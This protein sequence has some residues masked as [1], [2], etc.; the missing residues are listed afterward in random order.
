MLSRGKAY[1]FDDIC[2][3][4]DTDT[5]KS[6]REVIFKFLSDDRY[7]YQ[8]PN[9]VNSPRQKSIHALEGVYSKLNIMDKSHPVLIVCPSD[10]LHLLLNIATPC[11]HKF[12]D[13][14]FQKLESDMSSMK[15]MQASVEDLKLTVLALQSNLVLPPNRSSL[16]AAA[17][18]VFSASQRARTD[19]VKSVKRNLSTDSMD[20]GEDSDGFRLPTDQVKKLK[21]Q[22]LSGSYTSA[23]EK[24]AAK[25]NN[26]SSRKQGTWGKSLD[27]TSS[28]FAATV[29]DCFLYNCTLNTTADGIIKNLN[30]KGIAVKSAE[31]KS[32]EHAHTLSFRVSL[33][34]LVD[35]EKLIS[36][37]FIPKRMKVR[38]FIHFRR[39]TVDNNPGTNSKNKH[40][41]SYVYN[42]KP[43]ARELSPLVVYQNAINDLEELS[44][45][46]IRPEPVI[47]PFYTASTVP[48]SDQS[49]SKHSITDILMSGDQSSECHHV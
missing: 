46:V 41:P 36:G 21:R 28:D 12:D 26:I 16:P 4:F 37:L 43:V 11:D 42:S 32:P 29:P 13:E 35:F 24:G 23:V 17:D 18:Q 44:V 49:L 34:S 20:N 45:G 38:E 8:G 39:R 2:A 30:V 5:I 10:D 19:S 27:S 33:E 7:V 9:G 22:K 40:K 31:L 47:N 3:R 48:P 14:R 25:V 1:I 15:H 6:A